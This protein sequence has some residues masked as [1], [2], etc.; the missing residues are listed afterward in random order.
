MSTQELELRVAALE[1]KV[2]APRKGL[3][4]DDIN[5]LFREWLESR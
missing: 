3:S 5:R 4:M 2:N 1:A